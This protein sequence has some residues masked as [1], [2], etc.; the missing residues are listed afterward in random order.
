MIL[1]LILEL[2]SSTGILKRRVFIEPIPIKTTIEDCCVSFFSPPVEF[3][4]I[5]GLAANGS[6][7]INFK[8]RN[9]DG[10]FFNH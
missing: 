9:G 4:L 1:A 5:L 2:L 3:K 7:K 10:S 6:L 8:Q